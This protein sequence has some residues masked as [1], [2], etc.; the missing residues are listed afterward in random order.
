MKISVENINT[1]IFHQIRVYVARNR[2][3]TLTHQEV[4]DLW[5]EMPHDLKIAIKKV[6]IKGHGSWAYCKLN[7]EEVSNI[8]GNRTIKGF[9]G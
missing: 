5:A 9:K 8:R 3:F 1:A 2:W 4:N 6:S 7:R